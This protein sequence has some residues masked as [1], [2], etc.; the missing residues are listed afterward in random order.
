[1]ARSRMVDIYWPCCYVNRLGTDP[2]GQFYYTV[3]DYDGVVVGGS[4]ESRV[5]S[6]D[7]RKLIDSAQ[8]SA[9]RCRQSNQAQ[10]A[11]STRPV[12]TLA[13]SS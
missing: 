2:M 7:Y 12:D 8:G 6:G 5:D 4:S 10:P 13:S 11:S 3:I 1:M 9:P